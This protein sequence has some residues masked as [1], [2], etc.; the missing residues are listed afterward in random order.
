M[1]RAQVE[2]ILGAVQARY[3]RERGWLVLDEI[4][5]AENPPRRLD[6]L[7]VNYFSSN[8]LYRAGM[9]IKVE[10][11]DWLRELRDPTKALAGR[12][13]CNQFWVVALPGVVDRAEV[14]EGVG[15]FEYATRGDRKVLMARRQA[16]QVP[17]AT[18]CE[19]ALSR[20][21]RRAF[22]IRGAGT[23]QQRPVCDMATIQ[24][25]EERLAGAGLAA[26]VE[27]RRQA[28]EVA[29]KDRALRV[30]GDLLGSS[31]HG[32][33]IEWYGLDVEALKPLVAAARAA[34]A[35]GL[36]RHGAGLRRAL[37]ALEAVADAAGVAS[38]R[39]AEVVRLYPELFRG[40][41]HGHGDG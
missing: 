39:L 14:P 3:P 35:Q 30:Y 6:V 20:I 38:T 8:R 9:E 13:F 1:S 17:P 41:G 28:G 2:E 21:L 31:V 34:S 10:R 32:G 40:E 15:F 4:Q 11:G 5:V 36:E 22:G 27:K 16:A 26:L 24:R 25:L 7:A 19:A 12:G 33:E 18:P 37:R 29:D 23:T